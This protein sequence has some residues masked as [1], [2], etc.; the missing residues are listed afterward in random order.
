MTLTNDCV[1]F[2]FQ[3]LFQGKN[4]EYIDLL[5]MLLITGRSESNASNLFQLKLH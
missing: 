3:A 1:D 2:F 4:I 5:N